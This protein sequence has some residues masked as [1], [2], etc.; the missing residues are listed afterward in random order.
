MLFP[1]LV[2]ARDG[3]GALLGA[4]GQSARVGDRLEERD[5]L[6]KLGLD[7]S[8]PRDP[9]HDE[10]PDL[11][12]DRDVDDVVRLDGYVESL[13]AVDEEVLEVD[14]DGRG[15]SVRPFAQDENLVPGRLAEAPGHGYDLEQVLAADELVAPGV[16]DRPD[17][18]HLL[19]LVFL[20]ED[21]HLGVLDV[22]GLKQ[23]R[24][25]LDDALLGQPLDHD[26]PQERQR[27][28]SVLRYADGLVELLDLEDLDLEQVPRPDPIGPDEGVLGFLDLG[29]HLG[30]RLR[31]G[32]E[33]DLGQP[34]RRDDRDQG[35]SDKHHLLHHPLHPISGQARNRDM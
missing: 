19:V 31:L 24:Q 12:V 9:A 21:R 14:G 29:R 3:N 10:D 30:G 2:L 11:L 8:R 34:G 17:D 22:L 28:R 5:A 27:E 25:L 6:R 16:L 4:L 1:R 26:A 7:R 15:R 18:R 13:V 23:F 33:R 35:R 20:D 32:L